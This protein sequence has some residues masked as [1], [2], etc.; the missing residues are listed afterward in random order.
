MGDL[1]RFINRNKLLLLFL[2]LQ[3]ICFYLIFSY[4]SHHKGVLFSSVNSVTGSVEQFKSNTGDYF[5]L[6]ERNK[7]LVARIAELEEAMPSSYRIIDNT[8]VIKND[9]LFKRN[10]TYQA[11]KVIQSTKSMTNNYITIDK[12]T[13]Q[14]VDAKMVVRGNFGLIG[15]TDRSTKNF[16]LVKPIINPAFTAGVLVKRTGHFGLLTWDSKKG[17]RYAQL[18]DIPLDAKIKVGDEVITRGGGELYPEDIPIGTISDIVLE[19]GQ[20]FFTVDIALAED[21]SKLN[22]VYVIDNLFIQE[23]DSLNT[24]MNLDEENP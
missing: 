2:F 12:G 22:S 11:A 6:T 13:S 14:D 1:I 19:E 18:K 7:V 23:I 21:F 8:A 15:I 4:N 3:Y 9:S 17:Y 20:N 5:D 24:F 16:T 10:Y